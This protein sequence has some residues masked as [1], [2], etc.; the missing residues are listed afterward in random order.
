MCF[1][2]TGQY[3]V[4]THLFKN[5]ESEVVKKKIEILRKLPFK[6]VNYNNEV[7]SN[8]KNEALIYLW[9][10]VYKISSWNMIFT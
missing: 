7:V 6:V 9:L 10:E 3:L 8:I 5:L 4:E 2:R 1:V